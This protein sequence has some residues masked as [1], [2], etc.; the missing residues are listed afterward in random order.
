MSSGCKDVSESSFSEGALSTTAA[1]SCYR[2]ETEVSG[3]LEQLLVGLAPSE[4]STSS[5]FFQSSL[6]EMNLNLQNEAKS[7]PSTV[8]QMPLS[9]FDTWLLLDGANCFYGRDFR[10]W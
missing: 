8:D 6:A 2:N 3:G 5:D 1:W 4:P 9:F 10:I 7:D